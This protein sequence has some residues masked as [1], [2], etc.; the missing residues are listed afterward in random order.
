MRSQATQ[1]PHGLV[2]SSRG[3]NYINRHEDARRSQGVC[4]PHFE[5]EVDARSKAARIYSELSAK[6]KQFH[7]GYFDDLLKVEKVGFMREYVWSYLKQ[8]TWTEGEKPSNLA[9]FVS[10]NEG[11]F[12]ITKPKLAAAF[13]FDK[14]NATIARHSRVNLESRVSIPAFPGHCSFVVVGSYWSPNFDQG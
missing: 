3:A 1:P 11:I 10:W 6:D 2:I 8:S 5:E 9:T 13:L 7:D 12:P 14:S 4:I